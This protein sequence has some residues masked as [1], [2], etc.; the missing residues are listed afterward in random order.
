MTG[1]V[2]PYY[3]PDNRTM[4]DIVNVV[5]GQNVI[6]EGI[7]LNIVH[8]HHRHLMFRGG[9]Q[10]TR[11]SIPLGKDE[12]GGTRYDTGRKVQPFLWK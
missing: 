10:R 2:H 9:S 8:G 12:N 7:S 5:Y 1:T 4:N 3:L 6:C 11:I